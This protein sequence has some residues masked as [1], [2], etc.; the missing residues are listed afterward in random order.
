M[1][2][3]YLEQSRQRVRSD[4]DVVVQQQGIITHSGPQA[5]IANHIE[6]CGIRRQ[7]HDTNIR[8]ALA[9]TLQTAV[10]RAVVGNDDLREPAARG[11]AGFYRPQHVLTA[12]EVGDD[13]RYARLAQWFRHVNSDD[14][15][16]AGRRGD[17]PS[18]I[19]S[20]CR[21]RGS[22]RSA[23]TARG[24]RTRASRRARGSAPSG[25][26]YH[27]GGPDSG[28]FARAALASFASPLN[29]PGFRGRLRRPREAAPPPAPPGHAHGAPARWSRR[30]GRRRTLSPC[31]RYNAQTQRRPV[32]KG[33]D[34]HRR[35]TVCVPPG[36]PCSK[37]ARRPSRNALPRQDRASPRP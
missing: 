4:R 30:F 7:R 23:D 25:A 5:R 24:R 16:L 1:L 34:H 19:A 21:A 3:D 32:T 14:A 35:R 15:V 10:G 11:L 26:C 36:Y 17:G 33:Q 2:P 28:V 29:C 31:P 22:E 8:M 6:A 9:N 13:D 20:A 27:S 37:L 18:R 12:V